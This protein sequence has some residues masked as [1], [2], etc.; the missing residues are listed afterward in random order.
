[1]FC[2]SLTLLVAALLNLSHAQNETKIESTVQFLF[3]NYC[4]TALTLSPVSMR[5]TYPGQSA[6]E[7]SLGS[8]FDGKSRLTPNCIVQP[9]AAEEVSITVK[10]LTAASL[11]KPCQFAVRSGGHTPIPGSNNVDDGVTIDL[12]YMNS[13]TYDTGTKIA[14][15][16][17]AARWGSVYQTLEPLGRM[18]AGGRGSTV[19]VGG[20]LLGGGI[21]H[22][23]ARVGLSCDNVVNFQVVLADGR[24]VNSNK[25]K[26]ADLFTALKGGSSNFGIV[27]RYDMETF[28][29]ENLWGGIVTYPA[30]TADQ[31]FKALVNFG[32][33]PKRDPSAALIVFQG[34]STASPTDVVRA[35]FDYTKPVPRPD[36]YKEF[37][38]VA[39]NISDTTKVQPMSAVAAEFGSDTTKRV[40]F[41]TLSFKIDLA[42]LQETARLYKI[43]ITELQAKASG[44]W[45]VSCLHQVWSTRYT[46]N[47]MYKGGNVLGMERY[48]ENFIMYQSYLSWSEAKDD[49]LFINQGLALTDGIQKFASSK[50]TAVDY[51]YL[52]YADKDQDPLS[53]YGA[54]KVKFMR[55][56]ARKYDP[57][58]IYQNLLPGGF[59]IPNV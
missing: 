44:Q 50:G 22:Y 15:I 32:L 10:V 30:S 12:L 26:S 41:R 7:A 42:T 4:C 13:T 40:Q 20:F 39:N 18:V 37:F 16:S 49:E 57:S 45:R 43:M 53:A 21:S 34:Y 19:G 1:M 28:Q 14:S 6:Y 8:Y 33:N 51:L 54:D 52:N 23:A 31:H 46:A 9:K 11:L 5:V 29:N 48:T 27:T 24:I 3:P 59:K 47:S 36:A 56:V 55:T 17:P 38:A 25:N 35:A 2:L 58:G